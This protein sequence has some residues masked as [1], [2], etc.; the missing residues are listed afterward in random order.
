MVHRCGYILVLISHLLSWTKICVAMRW[1][2]AQEWEKA[3]LKLFH[4]FRHPR[5]AKSVANLFIKLNARPAVR[6]VMGVVLFYIVKYAPSDFVT[7]D[8]Q[9]IHEN[10]SML[11]KHYPLRGNSL[12]KRWYKTS[13]PMQFPK[14]M[15]NGEYIVS[16]SD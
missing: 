4:N 16:S 11:L 9:R 13:S 3:S 1:A 10:S 7:A 15:S 5:V 12:S 2:W 8:A 6:K 14:A